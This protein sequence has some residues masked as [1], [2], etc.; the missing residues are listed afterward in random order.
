MTRFVSSTHFYVEADPSSIV[1]SVRDVA[2]RRV[3]TATKRA[4]FLPRG[5]CKA[6]NWAARASRPMIVASDRFVATPLEKGQ[7]YQRMLDV[8][9][10]REDLSA[11]E[12]YRNI[13]NTLTRTGRYQHKRYEI[14]DPAEIPKL[15]ATCYLD[16]LESMSRDGYCADRT[17]EFATGGL[18]RAIVWQDGSLVHENGATHRLAAAKIVGLRHGFPFRIVG[19]HEDWLR[20]NGVGQRPKD[21]AVRWAVGLS[22]SVLCMDPNAVEDDVMAVQ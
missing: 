12:T 10:H 16:L 8:W 9:T 7:T 3:W 5:V 14:T 22:K 19:V 20:V 11:S 4:R 6:V 18:G 17:S 15:I 1:L 13:W 2:L 21:G